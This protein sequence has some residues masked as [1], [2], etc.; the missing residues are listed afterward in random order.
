MPRIRKTT[1]P[2]VPE[3]TQIVKKWII[4]GTPTVI[5]VSP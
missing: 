4:S 3:P 5:T 1:T 2:A